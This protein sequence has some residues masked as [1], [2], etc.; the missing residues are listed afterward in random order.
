[1][2]SYLEQIN[3][4]GIREIMNGMECPKDFSCLKEE[5]ENIKFSRPFEGQNIFKCLYEKAQAC[6]YSK[7][8]G[9]CYICKCPLLNHIDNICRELEM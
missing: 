3:K 6:P 2:G 9:Y 1:M 8:S 7:S 4:E 5:L